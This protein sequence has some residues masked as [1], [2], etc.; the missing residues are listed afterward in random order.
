MKIT[1]NIKELTQAAQAVK[2]FSKWL[3]CIKG[4]VM[5]SSTSDFRLTNVKRAIT[6]ARMAGVDVARVD[7]DPKTGVISVIPRSETKEAKPVNEADE[8]IAKLK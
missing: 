5:S 6:G 8:I 3:T 2:Y 1:C 4:G 7:I